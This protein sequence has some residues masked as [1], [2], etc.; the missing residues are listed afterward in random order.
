MLLLCHTTNDFYSQNFD[1]FE[2]A[3][4]ILSQ[5]RD[6]LENLLENHQSTCP[7]QIQLISS[8]TIQQT[9]HSVVQPFFLSQETGAERV[10]RILNC[11]WSQQQLQFTRRKLA[12]YHRFT[13]QLFVRSEK[14]CAFA[15]SK[16]WFTSKE[17]LK[18]NL[19][20]QRRA[21]RTAG[22]IS[23]IKLY[24]TSNLVAL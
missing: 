13:A 2:G 22:K 11:S 15:S 18:A 8:K 23:V 1:L 19:S 9:H 5:A 12:V 4:K 7:K 24:K 3:L 14:S 20:R 6:N 10:L 16:I 17:D 21:H